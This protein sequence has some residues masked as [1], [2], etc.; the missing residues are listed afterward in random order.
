MQKDWWVGYSKEDI[1][2]RKLPKKKI[3][4]GDGHLNNKLMK[5]REKDND[6]NVYI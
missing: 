4:E 3:V 5:E 1:A 2:K 6:L